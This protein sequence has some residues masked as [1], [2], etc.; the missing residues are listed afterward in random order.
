[1]NE[2]YSVQLKNAYRILVG[3]PERQMPFQ[4]SRWEDNIKVH[5]REYI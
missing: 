2:A 1:M 3:N 4:R 5:L